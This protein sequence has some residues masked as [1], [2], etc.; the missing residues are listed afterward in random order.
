MFIQSL[1]YNYVAFASDW[2]NA[3]IVLGPVLFIWLSILTWS[4]LYVV[5]KGYMV[6]ALKP[7]YTS[8]Y[9]WPTS[10][11]NFQKQLAFERQN[12]AYIFDKMKFVLLI[13]FSPLWIAGLVV[14]GSIICVYILLPVIVDV[15]LVILLIKLIF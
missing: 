6:G 9:F 10:W 8:P 2:V 5:V 15:L 1:I 11:S 7:S 3:N 13:L 4:L 14:C 12:A